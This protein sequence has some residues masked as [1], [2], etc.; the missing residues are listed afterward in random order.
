[1]KAKERASKLKIHYSII[2]NLS[3]TDKLVINSSLR[4]INLLLSS[5]QC[6]N[7]SDNFYK[8]WQEV[9]QEIEKL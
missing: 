2:L 9:K 5:V 8:Y 4:A 6:E 7:V 1:M 3:P